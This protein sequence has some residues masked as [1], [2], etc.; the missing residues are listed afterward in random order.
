MQVA[1]SIPAEDPTAWAEFTTRVK[2]GIIS[3]F[4]TNITLYEEDVRKA[5]SQ[6]ILPGWNFCSF[7]TQKVRT[8][9]EFATE[10]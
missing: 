8:F 10:T 3:R 4:D 1:Q 2:E 9:I 5:D 6:R 7:F